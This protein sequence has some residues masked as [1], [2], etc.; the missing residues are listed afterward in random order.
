MS[1]LYQITKEVKRCSP[2]SSSACRLN[3]AVDLPTTIILAKT[4]KKQGFS[5]YST[6]DSPLS[7][8]KVK[9]TADSIKKSH[10]QQC[11]GK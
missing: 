8:S 11:K 9:N 1:A 7:R 2:S 6:V 4:H 5:S 3:S 10:R